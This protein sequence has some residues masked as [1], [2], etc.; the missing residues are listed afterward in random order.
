MDF[1]RSLGGVRIV[2]EDFMG[3]ELVDDA[4]KGVRVD[5]DFP[6]I[7]IKVSGAPMVKE[8]EL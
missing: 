2:V 4:I 8:M 7:L 1:D 3:T 5:T 6:P